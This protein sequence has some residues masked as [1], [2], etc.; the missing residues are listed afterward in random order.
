MNKFSKMLLFLLLLIPIKVNGISEIKLECDPVI[1]KSG[2]KITCS[3]IGTSDYQVN[4]FSSN[5][6][7]SDNLSFNSFKKDDIWEGSSNVNKIGLYTSE[8]KKDTFK[9]GTLIIDVKDNVFDTNEYISL[10]NCVYSDY[11]YNKI[12]ISNTSINIRVL[13]LNN[14]LSSLEV[15]PGEI[16][17]NP[18]I[19]EYSFNTDSA[20]VKINA[21]S[22]DDKAIISGDI[23]I[24]KLKYGKNIL[25]ISVTSESKDVRIYTLNITRNDNRSG[26]GRLSDLSIDGYKI[27]FNENKYDYNISANHDVESIKVNAKL[28][29]SKSSFVSGYGSRNVSLKEGNNKVEVKIK[30]ENGSI[31]TYI[32]NIT[33]SENPENNNNYLENIEI[34]NNNLD[35]SKEQ[36]E[37]KV[38]VGND[39]NKL[40]IKTSLSS[41]KSKVEVFGNENFVVGDNIV[42]IKVTSLNGE[43]RE[44]KIIVNK[45][46]KDIVLSSNNYLSDLIINNYKL[47]FKKD[48]KDYKLKIK[49]E[50][51]LEIKAISEDDKSKISIKGNEKLKNKSV[52]TISVTA[53]DGSVRDYVIN[54][55]K[56]NSLVI[57]ISCGILFLCVLFGAII[58]FI[59]KKKKDKLYEDFR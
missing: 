18:D 22:E 25:K 1:V 55:K 32:I 21:I 31:S 49:E 44:Y 23:G 46:D 57:L 53:E 42:T 50:S 59:T 33:K 29:D 28:K 37:Y 51:T 17:F 9:I 5:I 7:L 43:V 6:V 26:E 36:Q 27:N 19:L 11:N 39:V 54:I 58:H 48:K 13:S 52:I 47:E 8:N 14:K 4:G 56:S 20:S 24:K 45:K 40:E 35:F 2:S 16:K 12:N 41:N 38:N 34:N 10:T 3:V 15:T 30:S